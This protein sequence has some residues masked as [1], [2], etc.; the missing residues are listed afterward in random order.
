[1]QQPSVSGRAS[2]LILDRSNQQVSNVIERPARAW[3]AC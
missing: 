1:M 3:L 2:P